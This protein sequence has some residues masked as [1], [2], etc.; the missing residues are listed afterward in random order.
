MKVFSHQSGSAFGLMT[1]FLHL[2]GRAAGSMPLLITAI[3]GGALPSVSREI[4]AVRA[5]YACPFQ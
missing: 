1:M 4:D 3:P 2:P 5:L